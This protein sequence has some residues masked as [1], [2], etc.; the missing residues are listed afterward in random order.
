MM[1]QKDMKV[2][3]F[4][5]WCGLPIY[6]A[7]FGWGKPSWVSSASFPRKDTIFLMDSRW[8]GGIDAWLNMNEQDMAE[9]E[10]DPDLQLY[11]SSSK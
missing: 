2:L 4:S 10:Q 1:S 3:R 6:E 8:N 9:F 11:I 5:S 7:D